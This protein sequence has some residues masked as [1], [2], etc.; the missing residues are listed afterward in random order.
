M[1]ISAALA[2][3]L[4]EID[5]SVR[6]VLLLLVEE[7]EK[8][9]E[10]MA[11]QVTRAEFNELKEVVADLVVAVRDLAEAQKRTEERVNQLAEAQARTE[12]RLNQLA[13]A[14]ARTEERL[15]Q[16][17]E[18]QARTEERLERLEVTV[19][20][21]IEAHKQADVRL[22]RLE[23]TVAELAEAQ[24]RTEEELRKLIADHRVTRDRV[25]GISH[26][27]GYTLEDRA[28]KSLPAILA[29]HG[30]HVEGRL[31]RRYV[32]VG[33]KE[34]QV[35]IYGHGHRNGQRVLI[36]GEAKIR[37]SRREVNRFLRLVRELEE[38]EGLPAVTLMVAYDFPPS[39]EAYIQEQGILPV[40]SY[41]LEL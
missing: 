18:A 39:I 26:T 27:V 36:L 4:T 11:Q 12:E 29:Q 24:K 20:E 38:R 30:I 21:L 25:E 35:N 32:Q 2:R 17:A 9:R 37:P 33:N 14:Q 34:R 5:P 15:N 6:E 10:Q 3:K 16:L 23:T 28:F 40:W 19:G 1:S 22:T 13:E 7:M 31:V 41:D 8:Q